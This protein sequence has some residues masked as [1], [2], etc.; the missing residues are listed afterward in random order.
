[1]LTF[2]R[3]PQVILQAMQETTANAT[4]PA[5]T[6]FASLLAT[7]ASSSTSPAA[8]GEGSLP[9]GQRSSAAS[10][11]DGLEDDIATLSYERALRAHARYRTSIQPLLSEP[12]AGPINREEPSPASLTALSQLSARSASGNEPARIAESTA[13]PDPELNRCR[14]TP[15]ERN[16]KS[17]SITIRLSKVECAQ[18]HRRAADA[19]LTISAYLRSCTFEA[20]SLRAMVKDTLAELRMAKAQAKPTDPEP[21]HRSWLARLAHLLTPWHGSQRVARA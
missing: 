14:A 15:F 2:C 11:D 21:P 17:A 4:T 18:L 12:D 8:R 7:L 9:A 10:S 13:N 1:L 6:S 3:L 20:E 19:G 16:L 5:T